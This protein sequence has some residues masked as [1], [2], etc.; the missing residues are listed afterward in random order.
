M[1]FH[2][3]TFEFLKFVFMLLIAGFLIRTVE[4]KWPQSKFSQAL[5]Y[6]Y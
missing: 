4:I 6:I 1:H 2:V 3:G 5:A